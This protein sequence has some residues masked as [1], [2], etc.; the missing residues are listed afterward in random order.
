[1][2]MGEGGGSSSDD[3]PVFTLNSDDSSA[4]VTEDARQ[5]IRMRERGA[6][7]VL[8]EAIAGS[9]LASASSLLSAADD[10][11]SVA[12]EGGGGSPDERAF[13]C[14]LR[15]RSIFSFNDVSSVELR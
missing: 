2:G 12:E 9:S 10:A 13:S 4:R 8:A 6:V 15:I 7:A 14:A 11:D 3:A 5:M 1:M